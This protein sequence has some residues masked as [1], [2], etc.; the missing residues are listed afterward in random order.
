MGMIAADQITAVFP[1]G[2]QRRE[3]IFGSDFETVV[4]LGDIAGGMNCES[5]GVITRAD[6]F[7]QA[8][9]F[10]GKRC[11]RLGFDPSPQCR[12][13]DQFH[14]PRIPTGQG[15][16]TRYSNLPVER[17]S[18]STSPPLGVDNCSTSRLDMVWTETLCAPGSKAT[19]AGDTPAG[20]PAP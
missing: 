11:A 5:A 15:A 14:G 7:D 18:T 20:A 4:T 12:R 8:A 2:L 19:M 6:A 13:Q 17:S 16:A 1:R 9:T 3:V 10:A